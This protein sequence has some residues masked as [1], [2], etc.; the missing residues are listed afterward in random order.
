MATESYITIAVI[1]IIIFFGIITYNRLVALR[2]TRKNS[3]ADIDV[4]LKLRYDIIPNLVETVK[5]YASHEKEVFENVT[6]ARA[7]AMK[8]NGITEQSR[9]EAT[10]DA[11]LMKLMAV[12]EN[13][14]ELKADGVFQDFS[15]KL[16]DVEYK[17]AAARRFFNNSTSEYNTYKEQFPAVLFAGMLGFK[18]GEFFELDEDRRTELDQAPEVKF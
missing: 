15:N 10:L 7:G 18:Q 8:A 3:F 13:Y 5:K 9:A 17:I 12:S 16:S 6:S 1:A 11:S 2:Q 4:Q 14:P